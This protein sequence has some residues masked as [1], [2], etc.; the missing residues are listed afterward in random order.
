MPQAITYK[1]IK[2]KFKTMLKIGV[3][4]GINWAEHVYKM[5]PMDLLLAHKY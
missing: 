3:D 5:D 4:I 2:A 1:I